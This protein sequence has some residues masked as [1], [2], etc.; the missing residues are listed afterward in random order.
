M[1]RS[2]DVG[3]LVAT[4]GGAD[5]RGGR[6]DDRCE[7]VGVEHRVVPL[8]DGQDAL[9]A[10][11]GVDVLLREL[12]PGAVGRLVELHEDQV[13][14]LDVTVLVP[15]LGAATLA[16]LG[17]LVDEDLRV[18][19]AGP[20]GPHGPEVVVVAHLWIRSG[21]SPTLS[22]Q[23]CS[24]SSSLSCTVTQRRS[25]S[26]PNT[27][28]SSSQ[29]KRDGV[30]FEVVAEAEVA[31][32]LEEGAVVG[33]GAHD[34][35][36]EGAEALLH[37][38]GPRPGSLLVTDEVRLERHHAGDGEQHR[39]VVRDQAGGGDGRMP[40]VGE[41]AGEGRPQFIG[42]HRPSLP[43]ATWGAGLSRPAQP[44]ASRPL[45]PAAIA[46]IGLFNG[47]P[48]IDPRNGASPKVKIPPSEATSQ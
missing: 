7:Q 29:A 46:S 36:V 3:L 48:P 25:P 39:R 37:A 42:V 15:E 22:I 33:V 12:G 20:R 21:R 32:H 43:A 38:G 27:S 11:P 18:R 30:F 8:Q 23:I 24:A 34:L 2:A 40:P 10:G 26:R 16:V 45:Q 13:P 47:T 14:Q 41:E 1:S 5:R 35:D 28:V 44:A 17:T 19:S 9:E 31:Q 6:L 4:V